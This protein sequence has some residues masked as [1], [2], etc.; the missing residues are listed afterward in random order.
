MKTKIRKIGSWQQWKS[1]RG[2]HN[3]EVVTINVAVIIGVF[4][5]ATILQFN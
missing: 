5:A 1:I 2:K 4:V 3:F